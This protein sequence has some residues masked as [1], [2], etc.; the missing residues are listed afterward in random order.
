MV[1][2]IPL[3]AAGAQLLGGAQGAGAARRAGERSAEL[4]EEE[5]AEQ[6]RRTERDFN[7]TLGQQ[8][9]VL[10]ASGVNI[11]GGTAA[12]IARDQQR[13]ADRQLEWIRRAGYLR[14]REAKAAARG[15]ARQSAGSGISGALGSLG[16]L[17][18]T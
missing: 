8:Q 7:F 14:Q 16:Q 11:Q 18:G 12:A 3:I 13:E 5:T 17:G 15:A 10:G 2:F 9:S 4:I 6:I 1:W